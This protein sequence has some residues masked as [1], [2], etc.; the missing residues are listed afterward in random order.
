MQQRNV[1][2]YYSDHDSVE[3]CFRAEF[4]MTLDA[5]EGVDAN[6]LGRDAYEEE[7]G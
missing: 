1:Q 5:P 7:V 6:G 4:E 2:K 3:H